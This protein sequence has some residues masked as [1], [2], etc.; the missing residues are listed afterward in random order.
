MN[1]PI[2][3]PESP[4]GLIVPPRLDHLYAPPI[5][6]GPNQQLRTEALKKLDKLAEMFVQP[7]QTKDAA[8]E[9]LEK[10]G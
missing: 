1:R 5:N 3:L 2:G 10:I 9:M 6:L 8:N 7:E 4:R